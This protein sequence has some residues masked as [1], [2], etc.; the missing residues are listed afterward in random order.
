MSLDTV[1]PPTLF[2]L[3]P[4]P[5][6]SAPEPRPM[7]RRAGH[8]LRVHNAWP[9]GQFIACT[10]TQQSPPSIARDPDALTHWAYQHLGIEYDT[11]IADRVHR[12][13]AR[14]SCDVTWTE[15]GPPL[16]HDEHMCLYRTTGPHTRHECRCGLDIVLEEDQ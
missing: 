7:R 14:G 6:S 8:K 3:E 4:E 9:S 11:A 5:A 1:M 15:S 13:S 10:C 12:L 16:P 2:D